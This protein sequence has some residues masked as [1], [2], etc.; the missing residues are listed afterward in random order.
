MQLDVQTEFEHQPPTL[1]GKYSSFNHRARNYV[2]SYRRPSSSG[3][4][5]IGRAIF[6]TFLFIVIFLVTLVVALF[7]LLG[8]EVELGDLTAGR[9]P[10]PVPNPTPTITPEPLVTP[11][12]GSLA[13]VR[14]VALGFA[15]D[16]PANWQK[17][18]TT[19]R[20]ILA[21]DPAGLYPENL[22]AVSLWAGIPADDTYEPADLLTDLLAKF[23]ADTQVL[24]TGSQNIGGQ[25]WTTVELSFTA[26][27]SAQGGRALLA[28]TNRNQVGYVMGA[29]TPAEQ[30]ESLQPILRGVINSFRF[31]QQAVIR[32]TDATRPPT[33]TPT[34][35]PQ[36]Y[37]VQSGDTLSWIAVQ[38]G[39]TVEALMLRNNIEDPRSLRSGQKL[40]IPTK[41]NRP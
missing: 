32:P 38:Y 36:I 11:I 1:C 16:Y 23:P 21:P 34:P 29:V 8:P 24:S 15:L 25:P 7:L 37:I 41:R 5:S 26:A 18:E 17:R 40:V 6:L 22:P 27:P 19:L 30:W 13:T 12:A 14:S 9:N 2:M 4:T 3:P 10:T 31:T 20:L 33:P 35:T 39:V 28:A